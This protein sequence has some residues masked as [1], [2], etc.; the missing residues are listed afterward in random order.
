[1]ATK[2][3]WS[4]MLTLALDLDLPWES[5][6]PILAPDELWVG[7]KI[8]FLSWLSQF[9]VRALGVVWR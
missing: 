4:E 8:D 5:L 9:K 7:G 6:Q 2:K 1:M 3:E